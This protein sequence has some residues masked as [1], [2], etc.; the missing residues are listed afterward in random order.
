MISITPFFLLACFAKKPR[1]SIACS[2]K[3]IGFGWLPAARVSGP[4][5]ASLC[6]CLP[7]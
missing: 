1:L 4:P 6:F 7:V 5:G 3:I 2:K